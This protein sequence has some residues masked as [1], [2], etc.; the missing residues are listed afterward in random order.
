[1]MGDSL[2]CEDDGERGDD[3]SLSSFA[4]LKHADFSFAAFPVSGAAD[5]SVPGVVT[6]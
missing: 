1:M 4:T 6:L 2:L 3:F 5:C